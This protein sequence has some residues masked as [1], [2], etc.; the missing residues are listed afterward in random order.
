[1]RSKQF[2][3]LLLS[4]LLVL[5]CG[6]GGDS[7]EKQSV[8]PS[9][10]AQ[11]TVLREELPDPPAIDPNKEEL[12]HTGTP[13]ERLLAK[14]ELLVERIHVERKENVFNIARSIDLGLTPIADKHH[15]LLEQ[16][17]ID[18]TLT[19][20]FVDLAVFVL[21]E[22]I[23]TNEDPHGI[24]A[25]KRIDR[26]RALIPDHARVESPEGEA[27]EEHGTSHPAG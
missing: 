19:L 25:K 27:P 3:P 15:D 23:L 9:G 22:K 2:V 5:R 13:A 10:S 4:A 1:M 17:L 6:S 18:T 26:I 12:F 7:D 20:A 11:E 14:Y 16:G 8:P 21:K 24:E